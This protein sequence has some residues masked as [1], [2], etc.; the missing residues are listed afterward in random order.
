[1]KVSDKGTANKE[2]SARFVYSEEERELLRSLVQKYARVI[3]NRRTNSTSV[4]AKNIAWRNLCADY[5][6]QPHIRPREEKQLRKLWDNLKNRWKKKDSQEKRDI[7]ATGGGPRTCSPMSPSLAL[8]GAVASHMTTRLP[9]PFDSDGEHRNQ[10]VLTLPPVAIFESMVN[11]RQDN[12]AA[13]LGTPPCDRPLSSVP[14]L[15]SSARPASPTVSVEPAASGGVTAEPYELEEEPMVPP[16]ASV[17]KRA[18]RSGSR[19]SAV[20]RML[21]PE[22]EA[23]IVLLQND[24]DR[25]QEKHKL[26]M[27]LLRGQRME[28]IRQ[29]RYQEKKKQA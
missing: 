2:H 17:T 7:H 21:A 10:P 13:S 11:Q 25:K 26:E 12:S 22:S 15:A 14:S 28:Q 4:E 20:E 23:R 9:N 6:S 18:S 29:R 16:A 27:R 3:E 8:V 1:M 19:M 5:N 24:E